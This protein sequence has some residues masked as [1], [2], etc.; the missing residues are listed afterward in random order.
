MPKRTGR[1]PDPMR[2]LQETSNEYSEK[3]SRISTIIQ[4]TQDFLSELPGKIEFEVAGEN[5]DIL[6]FERANKAW[7]LW[8][9]IRNHPPRPATQ[10]TVMEKAAFAPLLVQLVNGLQTETDRRLEAVRLGFDAVNELP[11]ELRG[12]K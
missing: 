4:S 8:Y 5:G 1:A 12:D 9:R 11:A 3:A 7:G 2:K 10:C 6:S